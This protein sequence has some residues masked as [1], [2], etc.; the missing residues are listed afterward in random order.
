MTGGSHSFL[1]AEEYVQR[2]AGEL[3]DLSQRALYAPSVFGYFRPGYVPPNTAFS[4]SGTTMPELQIVN[5]ATTAVWI[6]TV[7]PMV[8]SAIGWTGRTTDVSSTLEPNDQ[9]PA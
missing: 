4:A 8:G 3:A 1:V 9:A 5:E 7:M 2:M 6:N